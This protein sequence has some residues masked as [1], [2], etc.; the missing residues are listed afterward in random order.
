ME[1]SQGEVVR[2]VEYLVGRREKGR[3]Q[4][5]ALVAGMHRGIVPRA[6]HEG[7]QRQCVI[8]SIGP[9]EQVVCS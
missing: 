5:K 9:A 7:V 2:D 1:A 6:V 8:L 3:G 4:I